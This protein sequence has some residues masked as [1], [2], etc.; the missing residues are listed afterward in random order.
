MFLFSVFKLFTCL[1]CSRPYVGFLV[2]PLSLHSVEM[3]SSA[4][5]FRNERNAVE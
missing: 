3:T 2:I 4:M 5:S 1:L